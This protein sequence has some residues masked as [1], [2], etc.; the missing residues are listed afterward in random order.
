ME[1][2]V[3]NVK[4]TMRR[5]SSWESFE[6]S[7][8]PKDFLFISEFTF[9]FSTSHI[10]ALEQYCTPKCQFYWLILK[11]QRLAEPTLPLDLGCDCTQGKHCCVLIL[12]PLEEPI[13]CRK[14]HGHVVPITYLEHALCPVLAPFSLKGIHLGFLWKTVSVKDL[15]QAMTNFNIKNIKT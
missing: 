2:L 14:P 8:L 15:R 13:K 9:A 7:I 3:P 11:N 6:F 5:E 10:F 1:C 4:L 12:A